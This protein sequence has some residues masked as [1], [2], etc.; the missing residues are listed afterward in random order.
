MYSNIALAVAFAGLTAASPSPVSP[1]A[2][3]CTGTIASLD[4]VAAAVECTTVKIKSFTVPAGKALELNLLQETTVEMEGN[5]TFG[6]KNWKGP[7]FIVSGENITFNGNGHT[8]DGNGPEY[9]D[10]EGLNGGVTKP[11]PMMKIKISGVYKDV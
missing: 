7:L 3:Q 2:D 6:V 1:R 9:W 8:F 11:A 4:D 5:V 10:G